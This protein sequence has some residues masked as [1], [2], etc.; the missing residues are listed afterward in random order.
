MPAQ[1]TPSTLI[2][3]MELIREL[4]TRGAGKSARQLT[5]ALN[6]KGFSIKQR[7]VE[8]NLQELV[9]SFPNS[10]RINEGLPQGWLRH[11]EI[12]VVGM[13]L[14]DA[15]TLT[16]VEKAVTP[17]LSSAQLKTLQ[18][19]FDEARATIEKLEGSNEY[20]VWA[21][22]VR[23]VLPTLPMQTP[24]IGSEAFEAIQGALLK[25]EQVEVVY[26]AANASEPKTMP[27]NPLGI[28][29]RG[30]VIYLVA[31]AFGYTNP[32]LFALHR[33]ISARRTYLPLLPALKGF[34]L[35]AYLANGPLQFGDDESHGEEIG[36]RAI[37]S[38]SLAHILRETPLADDQVLSEGEAGW[39][40]TATVRNTLQLRWWVLSQGAGIEVLSPE[41]LRGKICKALREAADRYA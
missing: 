7:T 3:C 23:S 20:A 26:L 2:R 36:L 11:G 35:D 4:P 33:V 13:P 28:V 25:T 24:K 12:D 18:H 14:E 1:D 41:D 32:V 40:L 21:S 22:K 34:D 37:V 19:R 10:I 27:L 15:L 30:P 17:L 8:R 5:E 31:A 38:E 16:L 9:E 39:Q 29:Q 6:G